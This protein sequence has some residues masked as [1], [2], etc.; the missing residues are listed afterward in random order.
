MF[1]SKPSYQ[2]VCTL[3]S[4]WQH[5]SPS[6]GLHSSSQHQA[7]QT[8]NCVYEFLYFISMYIVH[9]LAGCGIQYHKTLREVIFCVWE[10]SEVFPY[11][12]MVIASSLIS[13]YKVSQKCS[14]FGQ[15]WTSLCIWMESYNIFSFMSSFICSILYLWDS[16]VL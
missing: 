6:P 7:A 8:L 10:C 14:T 9:P 11:K 3:S 16:F 12:L 1:H 4:K 2:A 5:Q 15:R 13:A